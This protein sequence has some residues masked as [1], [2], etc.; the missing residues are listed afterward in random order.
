[1]P[2]APKLLPEFPSPAALR[3]A[4]EAEAAAREAA[5][6]A[7]IAAALSHPS[8]RPLAV[9]P[10]MGYVPRYLQQRQRQPLVAPPVRQVG[11][12]R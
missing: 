11:G 12:L 6:Q 8:T 9:R 10:D 3:E 2:P 7:R 5:R 1:M 4:A